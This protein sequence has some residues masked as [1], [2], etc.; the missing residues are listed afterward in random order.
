M[1]YGVWLEVLAREKVPWHLP[2]L[3]PTPLRCLKQYHPFLEGSNLPVFLLTIA[4][5]IFVMSTAISTYIDELVSVKLHFGPHASENVLRV[6]R[7]FMTIK[8]ARGGLVDCIGI[9]K[10]AST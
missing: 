3:H 7:T 6:A 5:K 1:S 4:R 10:Q 8:N 9:S 2:H